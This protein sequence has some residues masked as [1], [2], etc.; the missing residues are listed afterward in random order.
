[1]NRLLLRRLAL[2]LPAAFWLPLAAGCKLVMNDFGPWSGPA[3]DERLASSALPLGSD[4]WRPN[5]AWSPL[6]EL[7]EVPIPETDVPLVRWM[8]PGLSE[9]LRRSEGDGVISSAARRRG[10]FPP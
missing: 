8:H 7:P 3:F 4:V 6:H 1:M 5:T 10:E 9:A 2:V